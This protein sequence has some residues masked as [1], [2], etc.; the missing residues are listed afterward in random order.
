MTYHSEI[1]T[2]F[3]LAAQVREHAN[4]HLGNKGLAG[5][6]HTFLEIAGNASDEALSGLCD[7]I[8]FYK[9]SDGSVGVRDNG[10]GVPLGWSDT[11]VNED[12]THGDW[13]WNRLFN[14]MYTSGKYDDDSMNSQLL[15]I[16][17]W[18]NFNPSDYPYLYTVGTHGV[19]ATVTQFTSAWFEVTS[20]T[21]AEALQMRFEKGHPVGE[22]KTTPSTEP[23]GTF[24]RWLP[25]SEVFTDTNITLS[26]I[27][28]QALM[29]SIISG[30]TYEVIDP[31]GTVTRYEGSTP[32]EYFSSKT[33]GYSYRK[34][35]HH[36]TDTYK[37][38]PRALLCESEIL[39]GSR[40]GEDRFWNN[41]VLVR[42]GVHGRAVNSV[43]ASFFKTYFTSKGIKVL[44]EDYYNA[45]TVY[46][47]TKA[48]HVDYQGQTK[49]EL[50][51]P[52]VGDAVEGNLT[53]LLNNALAHQESWLMQAL[54][55]VESRALDRQR[56]KLSDADL[57]AVKSIMK[58]SKIVAGFTPSI[59][60]TKRRGDSEL[61]IAEGESAASSVLQA[62]NSQTQSVFA[63]R[64]KP[65][66]TYKATLR[67]AIN[68]REISALAQIIG[69][70]IESGDE[71]T[72]DINKI[73]FSKIILASDAD[74]DGFHIRN[75]LFL[76]FWR[77]FPELLYSGRVFI[78]ETPRY[79][80]K[81]TN[82]QMVFYRDDESFQDGC[83]TY[84]GQI[85]GTQR[86]KGL[87]E[88]D[89][90]VLAETTIAPATRNL[91]QLII[92]PEDT[93]VIRTL[94]MMYGKDTLPRKEVILNQLNDAGYEGYTH[95]LNTLFQLEKAQLAT[96]PPSSL[97]V[98][99]V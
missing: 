73:R 91:V 3:G 58:P 57:K 47:F 24:V 76:L 17:D 10:S 5:C 14:M 38:K 71:R 67:D 81:L 92:S 22:L 70:G 28:D 99:K 33:D 18:D 54:N 46:V 30:V 78:A 87:G 65:L 41:M 98:L 50:N 12:G 19:G 49:N 88:V 32:E 95:F 61:F 56:R 64:G 1:K 29:S 35:F 51:S 4:V 15:A 37:G 27:Q 60:Y 20:Y 72:F 7:L 13:Y 53:A 42:A 9:F 83:K 11:L 31:E 80:I 82:G 85:A 79:A 94:E 6:Q 93:E 89:H 66:N 25:D 86:Y 96:L 21:G 16:T 40:F 48:N 69:C 63:L 77:Y 97:E 44:P 75:L 26:W 59:N 74:V 68:N 43:V 45:L 2:I 84:T 62:R 36:D 55:L 34:A 23:R 8:Q 90:T 39:V 52:Y